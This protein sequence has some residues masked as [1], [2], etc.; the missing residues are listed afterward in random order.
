ML[1]HAKTVL[2]LL[3]AHSFI[4]IGSLT[5][6]QYQIGWI[7]VDMYLKMYWRWSQPYLVH[8]TYHNQVLSQSPYCT[9]YVALTKI[10]NEHLTPAQTTLIPS[11]IL[12]RT[13]ISRPLYSNCTKPDAIHSFQASMLL[14]WN[15]N[16]LLET[17]SQTITNSIICCK[18]ICPNWPLA[19]KADPLVATHTQ[20]HGILIDLL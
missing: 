8:Y 14:I 5:F 2:I 1:E 9:N 12:S 15:H 4:A 17:C 6:M 3:C 7:Q 18:Q 11:N 10:S 13:I 16:S 20:E 19:I